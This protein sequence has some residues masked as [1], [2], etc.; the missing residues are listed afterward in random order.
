MATSTNPLA[1]KDQLIAQVSQE[2]LTRISHHWA[3]AKLP[4]VT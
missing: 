4:P 1:I 2:L 3:S